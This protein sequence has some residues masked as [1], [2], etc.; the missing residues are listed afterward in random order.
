M[1]STSDRSP[2]I[3]GTL[4]ERYFFMTDDENKNPGTPENRSLVVKRLQDEWIVEDERG[5]CLGSGKDRKS[6]IEIA[7]KAQKAGRGTSI[8]VEG[9]DG[10]HEA[11]I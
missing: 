8:S 4:D 9:E 2:C 3:Q 6:V 7:R 11:T 10:A 5:E 1:T